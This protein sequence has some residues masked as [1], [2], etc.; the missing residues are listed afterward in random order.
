VCKMKNIYKAI[1]EGISYGCILCVIATVVELQFSKNG[2]IAM[3]KLLYIKQLS[4]GIILGMAIAL[5]RMFYK[6]GKV[7]KVIQSVVGF[8]VSCVIYLI[9]LLK[10]GWFEIENLNKK[11]VELVIAAIIL[12]LISWIVVYFYNKDE[13]RKI[14]IKNELN[15]KN[16]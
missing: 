1:L 9:A 3:T 8:T 13:I 16:R 4:C 11:I 6:D 2:L 14:N 5:Q 7:S 15:K 12:I 10:T